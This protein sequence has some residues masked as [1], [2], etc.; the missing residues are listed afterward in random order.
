MPEA[1]HAMLLSDARQTS[2]LPANAPLP[3]RSVC[4]PDLDLRQVLRASEGRGHQIESISNLGSSWHPWRR[5]GAVGRISGSRFE[6]PAAVGGTASMKDLVWRHIGDRGVRPDFVVPALEP[7]QGEAETAVLERHHFVCKALFFEGADEAL[8][9]GDAAM[10]ANSAEPCV[11]VVV[12]APFEVVLAELA[13]LIADGVLRRASSTPGRLVKY[14]ADLGAR[15][16][17][18]ENSKAERTARAVVN[19]DCNPLACLGQDL[20]NGTENGE[21]GMVGGQSMGQLL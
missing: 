13:A 21:V 19:D 10:P 20:G 3:H 12:V 7:R 14:K 9:D 17:P 5:T 18:L 11:N 4:P 1:R 16:T 8:L 6:A 15:G 2:P